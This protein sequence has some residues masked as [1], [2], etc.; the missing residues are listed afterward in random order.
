MHI[1]ILQIVFSKFFFP[2]K[3]NEKLIKFLGNKYLFCK[4]ELYVDVQQ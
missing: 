4:W 3:K 1:P 2:S